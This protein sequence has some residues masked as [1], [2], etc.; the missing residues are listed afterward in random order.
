MNLKTILLVGAGLYLL[1][2]T[3]SASVSSAAPTSSPSDL[4]KLT[5]N[6]KGL[7]SIVPVNTSE[8]GFNY[9]AAL[10]NAGI[11]IPNGA[12]LIQVATPAASAAANAAYWAKMGGH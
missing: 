4:I 8:E 7:T 1:S 10:A 11:V 5:P 6:G 3:S 2:R 12:P 9:G